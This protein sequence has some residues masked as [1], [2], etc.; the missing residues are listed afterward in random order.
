MSNENPKQE[1]FY[2]VTFGGQYKKP[3]YDKI[4]VSEE[5]EEMEEFDSF[6][7]YVKYTLEEAEG[8]ANQHFALFYALTAEQ[9]DKLNELRNEAGN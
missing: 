5:D 4:V 6:E 2:C 9:L 7:E 1:T 8:E 3:Q